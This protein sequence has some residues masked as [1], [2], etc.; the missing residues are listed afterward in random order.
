[1]PPSASA[2]ISS[3]RGVGYSLETAT[4]DIIDNSIAAGAR[5]IDIDLDWNDGDLVVTILDDGSGM[6]EGEL[7]EAMR[8]GGMGPQRERGASDLGRFGLG[9]KTASLSQ[10]RQ[11]TVASSQGGT[12]FAFAWDVD[13]V[14][15]GDGGWDL[16]EGAKNV[17]RKAMGKLRSQGEGTAVVWRKVDFGRLDDR[18]DR[19]AI[20]SDIERLERHLGM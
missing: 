16:L 11:L 17:P 9:L 14:M 5:R 20:L 6:S 18:P 2:L 12:L 8:F 3:L 19:A 7:V 4:A 15:Q 10:C 1:I 13:V